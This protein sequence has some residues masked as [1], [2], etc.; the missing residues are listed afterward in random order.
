[1]LRFLVDN[2]ELAAVL[3]HEI[4]HN[5]LGHVQAQQQNRIDASFGA[6]VDTSAAVRAMNARGESGKQPLDANH[7]VSYSPD[8]QVFVDLY[9][10]VDVAPVMQLRR[11]SDAKVVSELERADASALLATGW[12]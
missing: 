4:A 12:R 7:T 9:S 3:A 11:S 10:R 1:M 2:D 6:I 5:A 8:H